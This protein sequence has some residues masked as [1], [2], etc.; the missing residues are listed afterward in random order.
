MLSSMQLCN[1]TNNGSEWADEQLAMSVW[2]MS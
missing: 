2:I 1:A